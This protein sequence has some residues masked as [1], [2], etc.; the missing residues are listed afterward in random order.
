MRPGADV[1]FETD[2]MIPGIA[3]N[4]NS[5]L[6]NVVQIYYELQVE[7]NVSGCHRNILITIPVTIGSVA[8]AFNEAFGFS[9]N[10]LPQAD[11]PSALPETSAPP[12]DDLR[13]FSFRK[14]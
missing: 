9:N 14:F 3:M 12:F 7:A 11:Y 10:M 4:T 2:L 8:L 1:C 13:K 6:C 5:H